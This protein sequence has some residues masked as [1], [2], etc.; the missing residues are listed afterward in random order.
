MQDIRSQR[1]SER[2]A[3]LAEI[4]LAGYLTDPLV[5]DAMMRVP[6]H[7]FVPEELEDLAYEDRP[8]PIAFEQTISAPHMVAMMTSALQL[9]PGDKVL[10]VGTGAGYHAAILEHVVGPEGSVTSVEYLPELAQL[11]RDNLAKIDSKVKV[12]VG[13]GADG[14]RDGAPYDA[15]LVTCA[16]PRI[17]ETLMAQV[18]EGGHLVAP[19]GIT[20]CSLLA[21]KLTTGHFHADD[22]G[23]CLF[24]NVQ[25]SLAPPKELPSPSD[26]EE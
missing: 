1:R 15:V 3:L 17:P 12:V 22:L 5:E 7:L 8:L 4:E 9:Q 18:R 25:G 2:E 19:V 21:G 13:D 20:R 11:A 26:E 14:H 6:R 10:E 16:I 24:V 23:P